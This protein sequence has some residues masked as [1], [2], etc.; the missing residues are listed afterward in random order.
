MIRSILSN[1]L[2]AAMQIPKMRDNLDHGFSIQFYHSPEN[3]MART[4]LC[5]ALLM[6]GRASEAI[7]HAEQAVTLSSGQDPLILD[8][9]GRLYAQTGRLPE[10]IEATRRALEIASRANDRLLVRDLRARLASYG[11]AAGGG[12]PE[13]ARTPSR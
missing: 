1:F 9:L 6:A 11:N 2:N 4:N 12:Q 3:P 5:L 10:A 7:P 13:S 8:L